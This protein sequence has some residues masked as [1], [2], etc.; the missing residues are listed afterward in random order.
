MIE[1]GLDYKK[2]QV[3]FILHQSNI[4][5]YND[6]LNNFDNSNVELNIFTNRTD[7]EESDKF[8]FFCDGLD[9]LFE[10]CDCA[11]KVY[12]NRCVYYDLDIIENLTELNNKNKLTYESHSDEV[13]IVLSHANT[14]E[15]L[16]TL[17]ECI[18]VLKIQNQKI[19]LVSHISAP[20]FIID[21][22]DYFVFDKKNE[23]I[24]PREFG[25]IGRTWAYFN[26]NGYY[27]EYNYDNHAFAVLKLFKTGLSLAIANNFKISHLIH[28]DCIL[29][30]GEVLKNHYNELKDFDIYHYFFEG[31]NHRMDGNFFS[32]KTQEFL[33]LLK[34]INSKFDYLNHGKSIFEDFL[35]KI[36][37]ESV[38][39]IKLDPI[40]SLFYKNIVDKIKMLNLAIFK[41]YE[42]EDKITET[43]VIPSK[44]PSGNKYLA[45]STS[46]NNVTKIIVN[47][48][49]YPIQTNEIT[50]LKIDDKLIE[51]KI[52]IEIPEINH[53]EKISK[54]I[55]FAECLYCD[56]ELVNFF[57]ITN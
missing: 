30:D 12:D 24:G 1:I 38:L 33:N 39:K 47:Q 55:K 50:L 41:E 31:Y 27:H 2:V 40:E 51:E 10:I 25:G 36:C 6:L 11:Y 46:D 43:Y 16:E 57:D 32:V 5:Q 37:G 13:S 53:R 42:V 15:K 29:Y 52:I 7:I 8:N 44:E 19:I 54:D 45:I 18:D 3:L 17:K 28:Y 48:K 35:K 4:D 9:E 22:V 23:L 49:E 14:D 56:Y 20:Q 21:S 26:Y 34:N